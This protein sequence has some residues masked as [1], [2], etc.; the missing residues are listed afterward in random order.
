M[1]RADIYLHLQ[2]VHLQYIAG[3]AAS[4]ITARVFGIRYVS[5]PLLKEGSSR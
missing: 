1:T 4:R 3:V 2:D 5:L